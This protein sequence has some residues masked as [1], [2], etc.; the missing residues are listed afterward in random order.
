MYN[1]LQFAPFGSVV[2]GT[3]QISITFMGDL[4]KLAYYMWLS[5]A[6]WI[7]FVCPVG[8]DGKSYLM[9]RKVIKESIYPLGYYLSSIFL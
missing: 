1:C 4:K 6:I 8:I 2:T 5:L 9:T 7:W 3:G